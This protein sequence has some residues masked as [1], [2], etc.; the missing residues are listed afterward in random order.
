MVS[1]FVEYCNTTRSSMVRGHLPPVREE[2]NEVES[3]NLDDVEVQSHVG[4]L[5]KS[6]VRKA[7]YRLGALFEPTG[8]ALADAIIGRQLP[9]I[10]PRG[11]EQ[12]GLLS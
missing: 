10:A 7:A 2:P 8:L 1:E 9:A 5:V 4:G 11:V 6:F 12:L 3:L